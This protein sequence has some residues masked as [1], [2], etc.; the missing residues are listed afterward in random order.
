MTEPTTLGAY[1]RAMRRRRRVSIE[2]AAEDTRIRADFLMRM[3]SDE[4]D[5]LAPAYVRGFLKSYSRYLGIDPEPMT[6]EF[7]RRYG[8]GRVDTSQLVALQRRGRRRVPREPIK[9]NPV[10]LGIVAIAG[11]LGVLGLVGLITGPDDKPISERIAEARSS[12]G[13]SPSSTPSS[14]PSAPSCSMTGSKSRSSRSATNAGWM[15]RR[16]GPTFS[17]T[18]L[19]RARARDRLARMRTLG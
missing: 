18:C 12:V 4:F 15:S 3:E 6:A 19:A 8:G 5:F 9:L 16:T 7:D 17:K 10:A 2:R 13:V 11:S 14:E 1:L